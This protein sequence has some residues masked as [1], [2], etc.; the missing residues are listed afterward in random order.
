MGPILPHRAARGGGPRRRDPGQPLLDIARVVVIQGSFGLF[1]GI[2][3]WRYRNLAA[4]VVI[5]VIANGWGV[6]VVL[7]DG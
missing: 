3:W 7:I 1:L 4:I 2:M 5:H 6:A